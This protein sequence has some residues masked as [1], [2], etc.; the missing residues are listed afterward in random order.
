M[1]LGS[2]SFRLR[3]IPVAVRKSETHAQ[4]WLW[5]LNPRRMED[6]QRGASYHIS[7]MLYTRIRQH[8]VR[9]HGARFK[10]HANN[11]RKFVGRAR[12]HPLDGAVSL[13]RAD[14]S[15][16]VAILLCFGYE[17]TT[18]VQR[19]DG[20]LLRFDKDLNLHQSGTSENQRL[21]R[22]SLR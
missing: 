21:P 4:R 11:S 19:R 8:L 22:A 15:H 17:N 9:K 18:H 3:L 6:W 2:R 16:I 7:D 5:Q 14:M 10:E 12:V 13:P 1:L 20:E